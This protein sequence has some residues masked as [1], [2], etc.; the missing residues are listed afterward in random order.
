MQT[1]IIQILFLLDYSTR[2]I[3]L[4]PRKFEFQEPEFL[5]KNFFPILPLSKIDSVAEISIYLIYYLYIS[6]SD[7]IKIISNQNTYVFRGIKYYPYLGYYTIRNDSIK[8]AR[9]GRWMKILVSIKITHDFRREAEFHNF[10]KGNRRRACIYASVCVRGHKRPRKEQHPRVRNSISF[11]KWKMF[12]FYPILPTSR[13][14]IRVLP[15][16]IS[17]RVFTRI[18]KLFNKNGRG[19][20]PSPSS[21][22]LL[23]LE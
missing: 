19:A 22:W 15:D 2:Y 10:A 23:I 17:R 5:G 20:A 7:N 3:H 13:L 9:I 11:E 14:A 8:I 12:R 4:P 21:L 18:L 6:T 16:D 1:L